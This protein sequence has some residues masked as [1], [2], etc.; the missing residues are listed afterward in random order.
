[1]LPFSVI[2]TV[3]MILHIFTDFFPMKY[4]LFLFISFFWSIA[5]LFRFK[6]N[7]TNFATKFGII[8]YRILFYQIC[9]KKICPC[10]SRFYLSFEKSLF[11]FYG[12]VWQL[13]QRTIK[14]PKII[15]MNT[16]NGGKK[17]ISLVPLSREGVFCRKTKS[18]KV[19]F[20]KT[21]YK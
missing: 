2:F 17:I 12:L 8:K 1:M 18:V 4:I 20:P 15:Y 7:L 3:K 13:P 16:I 11:D 9:A 21:V 19:I 14:V 10:R 6:I 5:K